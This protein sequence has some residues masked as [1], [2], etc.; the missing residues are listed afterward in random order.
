MPADYLD[1]QEALR[2]LNLY[3]DVEA[4]RSSLLHGDRASR[5]EGEC[6][7]AFRRLWQL[8]RYVV[9]MHPDEQTR[10]LH[11][12]ALGLLADSWDVPPLVTQRGLR[13]ET[14]A[15]LLSILTQFQVAL[16]RLRIRIRET[17]DTPL[18]Q[19]LQDSLDELT[20][21]VARLAAHV[22]A[23][24]AVYDLLM[25]RPAYRVLQQWLFGESPAMEVDE[26]EL[27]IE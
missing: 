12:K 15:H 8:L 21:P 6:T 19:R 5:W 7:E 13:P 23:L 27:E 16:F 3:F 17:G 20:L 24:S 2:Q 14:A 22:H 25:V 10:A 11:N 18:V 1:T 9:E 4:L 26:E